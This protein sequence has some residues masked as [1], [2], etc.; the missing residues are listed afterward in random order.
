MR[1]DELLL[2]MSDEDDFQLTPEDLLDE[3]DISLYNKLVRDMDNFVKTFEDTLESK[4][5]KY[6]KDYRTYGFEKA[7]EYYRGYGKDNFK[8]ED[9]PLIFLTITKYRDFGYSKEKLSEEILVLT[10]EALNELYK[11]Q[12]GP[13]IPKSVYGENKFSITDKSGRKYIYEI[14]KR[15]TDFSNLQA[16]YEN[17]KFKSLYQLGK[18]VKL[19]LEMVVLTNDKNKELKDYLEIIRY[20]YKSNDILLF[21]LNQGWY[22]KYVIGAGI[23]IDIENGKNFNEEINRLQKVLEENGFQLNYIN[24]RYAL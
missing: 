21:E 18:A 3:N 24:K 2:F 10:N 9:I 14:S 7:S 12:L 15:L 16:W 11:Y 19:F 20:L 5:I 17:D 13:Y 6:Y 8:S 1:D 23:V 22:N 4:K